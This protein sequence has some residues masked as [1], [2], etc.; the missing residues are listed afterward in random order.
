MY[1]LY[2]SID[3]LSDVNGMLSYFQR[4]T[5]V[6]TPHSEHVQIVPELSIFCVSTIIMHCLNLYGLEI[7]RASAQVSCLLRAQPMK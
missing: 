2:S 1:G 5:K 3:L 6:S 4:T 7:H